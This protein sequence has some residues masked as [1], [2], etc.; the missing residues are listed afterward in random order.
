[1][2]STSFIL[3]V[4][5]ALTVSGCN[6]ADVKTNDE[7]SPVIQSTEVNYSV[8]S[9][10]FRGWIAWDSTIHGK[11]PGVIVVHEWWGHNEY[12]RKRA[13]MLA[14]MGYTAFAIDMYGDGKQA[15]HPDSAMA[16]IQQAL[17][18]AEGAKARFDK[19][20]E[21]LKKHATVDSVKIAAIGYCF[22]GTVVLEMARA[23][24]D[25][26]G[27]VSYHGGLG[28]ENPAQS[29]I[30]KARVLVCTGSADPMIPEASVKDFES[31][32][33]AAGV[34]YRVIRYPDATHAFTNPDADSLGKLFS[35]PIAYNAQADTASWKATDEFLTT[36]FKK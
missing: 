23:G 6:T 28:T 26:D 17:A 13:R 4:L 9:L 11:R 2:Q 22:G 15:N 1:M 5:C 27:V 32:M 21:V 20:V 34:N 35:M 19:A 29:G 36:L 30:L 31:E 10:N 8:D 24:A 12:A 33:N 7:K 3:L 14:G 25:L 18:T 16:F